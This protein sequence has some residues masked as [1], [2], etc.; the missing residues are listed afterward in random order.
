MPCQLAFYKATS[1]TLW[2]RLISLWTGGP[3][4]HVELA[5]PDVS[6]DDPSLGAWPH[7]PG[8]T[9]CFS[10]SEQDGG[11]RF[12]VIDLKD[13]KWDVVDV[14]NVSEAL[15]IRDAQKYNHLKY[16]WMAILG[17]VLQDAPAAKDEYMCSE[18][19]TTLLQLQGQLNDLKPARTSPNAL[20]KRVTQ[21][22]S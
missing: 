13:G 12:K 19:C 21:P 11:T 14:P 2:S 7:D 17:F 22:L 6:P 18:M 20:Y 4:S 9:L 3:Y 15:L 10:S 8:G 5:M 1:G 16:D